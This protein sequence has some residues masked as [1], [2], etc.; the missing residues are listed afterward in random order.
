MVVLMEMGDSVDYFDPATWTV[1][2]G[3]QTIIIMKGNDQFLAINITDT[4]NAN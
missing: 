2:G 3:L 4:T 1:A